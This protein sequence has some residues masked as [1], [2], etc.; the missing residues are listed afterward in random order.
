MFLLKNRKRERVNY[1]FVKYLRL[2]RDIYACEISNVFST[3]ISVLCSCNISWLFFE[4]WIESY[5]YRCFRKWNYGLASMVIAISRIAYGPMCL[6]IA[7]ENQPGT[8]PFNYSH[9]RLDS[10]DCD[11]LLQTSGYCWAKSPLNQVSR[12]EILRFCAA[13]APRKC[14]KMMI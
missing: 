10:F 11:Y 14:T 7:P 5:C 1:K 3:E 9:D 2:F 4:Y 8:S 12:L 6:R 13:L